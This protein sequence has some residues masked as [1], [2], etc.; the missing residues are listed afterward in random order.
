VEEICA[1]L[2]IQVKDLFFDTVGDAHARREVRR[3][4]QDRKQRR[5]AAHQV[6]SAQADLLR[7]AEAVIQAATGVDIS[8]WSDEQLDKAME[9]VCRARRVLIEEER[10]CM[11]A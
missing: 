5:V 7:E 4:S 10:E 8:E 2:G 3:Q 9:A 6:K 11:M 1:A